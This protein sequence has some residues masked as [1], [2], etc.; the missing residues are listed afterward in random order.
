MKMCGSRHTRK[1]G[2][3]SYME[4]V[5]QI[6]ATGI[7][8]I[9]V[10]IPYW[11]THFD[12]WEQSWASFDDYTV[13]A[14]QREDR[15]GCKER[16]ETRRFPGCQF[17]QVARFSDR[18]HDRLHEGNSSECPQREC[19]HHADSGNLSGHRRRS[20]ASRSRRLRNVRV[21]DVIAHEYEFG[22]GDHMAAVRSQV[23]WMLYQAGMLTF[24]LLLRA[25]PPGY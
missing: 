16:S 7:D 14:F 9:Y 18:D 20:D 22:N 11:M 17:P 6:A 12:G 3:S 4:R 23:D 5:R 24:R 25:R 10:D 19:E 21:I 2:A 15:T 1:S 8:G 13:A